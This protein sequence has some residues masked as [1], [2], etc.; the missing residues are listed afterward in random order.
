M[1]DIDCFCHDRTMAKAMGTCV[2]QACS[3]PDIF[4]VRRL[5]DT[6]CGVK[7]KAQTEV[8]V[9]VSTIFLVIMIVCA[10]MRTAARVLNRNYGLDDLAISLGVGIA[11]AIGVIVYP[12]C[13]LGLGK[14]IWYLERPKIDRI[15]YVSIA[16]AFSERL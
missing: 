11:V 6:V 13:N 16:A 8:L 2:V 1:T 7:P 5:S 10:L 14:D 12:V 3:A 15:L 9:I 4:A